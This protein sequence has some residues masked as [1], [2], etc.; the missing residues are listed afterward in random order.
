MFDSKLV[1]L[2]C[3]LRYKERKRFRAF[4]ASPFFNSNEQ[5]SRLNEAIEEAFFELGNKETDKTWIFHRVFG[6]EKAYD[7]SRMRLL[8]SDLL[9]LVEEFLAYL[10][11]ASD[12]VASRYYLLREL[13]QRQQDKHF[14]AVM[15]A[16]QKSMEQGKLRN[17]SFYL[18]EHMLAV[19]QKN[20]AF[21]QK[22][23]RSKR[24]DFF[25]AGQ[26]LDHY[27]LTAKLRFC[28]ESLSTGNVLQV[29]PDLDLL[30]EV[31]SYLETRNYEHI[32]PIPVYYT[33]LQLLMQEDAEP[34]YEKLRELVDEYGAQFPPEE[35][36]EIYGY[37]INYCIR[38]SNS[39]TP[40]FRKD[41]L[42][43]YRR[44]LEEGLLYTGNHLM[45]W[46]YKNIVTAGLNVGEY[47]WV[48]SFI[49]KYKPKLEARY[50][51]N[52]YTYNLARYYFEQKD[53]DRV[54]QLLQKVE[55]EDVFYNLG[56]KTMLLRI[57][58]ELEET[59]ALHS[60]FDSFG[61]FLRRNKVISD[62]HRTNYLNMIR[63]LKKLNTIPQGEDGKLSALRSEV[64]KTKQIADISWLLDQI[65]RR[66]EIGLRK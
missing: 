10:S 51:K 36:W 50:R 18:D 24:T 21:R 54:L 65:D 20:Y 34:W 52:A 1:R 58:F 55:Y 60:L 39:G 47:E 42:D 64:E 46:D 59:D 33:I 32:P 15:R 35:L 3:S 6:E 45:H 41:L 66:K 43:W 62:G 37:A 44:A 26:S 14:A 13:N 23:V 25:E 19:E 30:E 11:F 9:K 7:D 4:L 57:Y 8:M 12:K 63:Y 48:R 31:L 53:Y 2:I 56:A 5:L 22:G 49:D 16:L 61:V 29:E 38:R 40:S 27:Y 28:C 17:D